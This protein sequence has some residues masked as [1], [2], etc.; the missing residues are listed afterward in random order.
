MKMLVA[1][2]T[3]AWLLVGSSTAFAQNPFRWLRDRFRPTPPSIDNRY[4]DCNALQM[5]VA[6]EPIWSPTYYNLGVPPSAVEEYVAALRALTKKVCKGEDPTLVFQAIDRWHATVDSGLASAVG[7]D[8]SRAGRLR[9]DILAGILERHERACFPSQQAAS[10]LYFQR[11]PETPD[12]GLGLSET[13]ISAALGQCNVSSS[14]GGISDR[15]KQRRN[16]FDSDGFL[17][18]LGSFRNAYATCQSPAG[19][20]P[21][22]TSLTPVADEA[23]RRETMMH[24]ACGGICPET[25][26]TNPSGG[27]W[28]QIR[29]QR[30]ETPA[31]P[32][33]PPSPAVPR[34]P[35]MD[36]KLTIHLTEDGEIFGYE[37]ESRSELADGT[38]MVLRERDLRG[39]SE[40][41]A[42]TLERW[43]GWLRP[44]GVLVGLLPNRGG[45]GLCVAA[46]SRNGEPIGY[47][48]PI[49]EGVPTPGPISVP[50]MNAYCLCQSGSL[51]EQLANASGFSCNDNEWLKRLN[52]LARPLGPTDHV[53]P[54]CLRYLA[55]D[56]VRT[57]PDVLCESVWR[58]PENSA[59]VA[60]E[61]A[62]G[63]R[64]GCRRTM[65]G[66]GGRAINPRCATVR[67]TEESTGPCCMRGAFPLPVRPSIR[68][69]RDAIRD[70]GRYRGVLQY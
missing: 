14:L 40:G 60:D 17:S 57:A 30:P 11:L 4:I 50:D 47:G 37:F 20:D 25:G 12:Y 42:T 28:R 59:S 1:I 32:A 7:I 56:G 55:E 38:P 54:E 64:C 39:R 9:E 46:D 62:P 16:R 68:L 43:L 27:R 53:R 41:T 66:G 48:R 35:P 2:V 36:L 15:S 13:P 34:T 70:A 23:R 22:G 69:D 31:Q 61:S 26:G 44:I 63:I 45:G 65:L 6:R 58:C 8:V 10:S 3:V 67:C 51:G 29:Y 18:C 24:A 21:S 19:D 52:C 49:G 33:N 5:F